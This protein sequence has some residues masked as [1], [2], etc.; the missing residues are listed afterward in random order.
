MRVHMNE[1]GLSRLRPLVN[2]G[3]DLARMA[4]A[5]GASD[6]EMIDLLAA[7]LVD[8]GRDLTPEQL[9]ESH[10]LIAGYCMLELAKVQREIEQLQRELGNAQEAQDA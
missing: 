7:G 3:V 10:A 2:S 4:P 1:E 5:T 6:C 9:A 8:S